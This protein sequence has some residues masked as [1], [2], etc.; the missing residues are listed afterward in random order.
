MHQS[1]NVPAR[2][3]NVERFDKI[4]L[5]ESRTPRWRIIASL[6]GWIV[7]TGGELVELV[8]AEFRGTTRPRIIVER[9]L[10]AALFE[11]I[12]PIVDGLTIPPI[13]VLNLSWREPF[14][15]LARSGEAFDCFRVGLVRELLA[16]STFRQVGDLVPFLRHTGTCYSRVPR[17][18]TDSIRPVVLM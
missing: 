10:K 13:L 2:E 16:D 12:Q 18:P 9:G 15:I 7:E 1:A 3:C 14:E 8:V 11:P 6:F 5:S 4:L 17:V